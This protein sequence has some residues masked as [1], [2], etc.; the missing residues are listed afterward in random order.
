MGNTRITLSNNMN[1]HRQIRKKFKDMLIL[2]GV[3]TEL[4]IAR[5]ELEKIKTPTQWRLKI[6]STKCYSKKKMVSFLIIILLKHSQP[7]ITKN[8]KHSN[9]LIKITLNKA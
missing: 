5:K 7:I 1:S 4:K 8:L 3:I 9:L 2:V 6:I